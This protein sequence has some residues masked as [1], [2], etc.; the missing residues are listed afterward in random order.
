MWLHV[1]STSLPNVP[2]PAGSSSDS[3]S[4]SPEPELWCT[5]NGKPTP[6]PASWR[7]WKTRPWIKR[8]CGMTLPASTL[9]RGADSWIS[10]LRATRAS[11]TASP[12]KDSATTTIAGCST[13]SCESSPTAGLILSS[14]RTCRGTPPDSS[15][16]SSR[17]WRDWAAALRLDY[18]AR[19]KSAPATGGNGCS[20]WPTADATNRVLDEETIA[21]CAAFRKHNANQNT[22]PLYL[23]EV[24]S[25]WP[26]PSMT[27]GNRGDYT[28]DNGDPDKPRPSLGGAAKEWATPA[29]HE[30]AQA[31]RTVDHGI[32]LANQVANWPTPASR[33]YKGENGPAHLE[34]GTGR[35]HLD[36]L[37]NFVK[38]R[39]SPPGQ[40]PPDGPPSSKS[41]RTLN[42]LFVEWLQGWPSGWTDCDSAV[43]GLSRYRQLMR[44]ELSMLCSRPPEQASLF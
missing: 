15:R 19:R 20:S 33:D 44:T 43:T 35:L 13:T 30:R 12:G 28:R 22:V 27:D 31:P 25:N 9:Q 8:L 41:R 11:P 36:Q 6:R 21:K 5:S 42:P 23:A 16:F 34:N 14:A 37:P 32:Q 2:V 7:G 29:A 10:S 4:P 39:F 24:A 1:P 40:P 38:Y 17:H 18:S 26:S 3:R